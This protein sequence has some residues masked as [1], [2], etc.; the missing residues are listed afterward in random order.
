MSGTL[1]LLPLEGGGFLDC[2]VRATLARRIETRDAP[3]FLF[4]GVRLTDAGIRTA[5]TQ[6]ADYVRWGSTKRVMNLRKEQQD[7]LWVAVVHSAFPL[8]FPAASFPL[9]G[10]GPPSTFGMDHLGSVVGRLTPRLPS[11]ASPTPDRRFRKV[12]ARRLE[13][14]PLARLCFS[15]RHRH[16]H[17]HRRRRGRAVTGRGPGQERTLPGVLA[18]P[19]GPFFHSGFRRVGHGRAR[20]CSP[21]EEGRCASLFSSGTRTHT[22][23]LSL[24]I[25]CR[26]NG[27]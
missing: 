23:T 8:S 3:R 7:S 11:T 5:T 1:W 10:I 17:R 14:G 2:G 12:L 24:C 9:P 25:G 13:T 15:C 22:H 21:D 4:S 18:A 16:R 6:E 26:L 27:S 19:V 20:A